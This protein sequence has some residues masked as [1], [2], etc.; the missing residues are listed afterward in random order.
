MIESGGE[1]STDK[2][3]YFGGRSERGLLN[4]RKEGTDRRESRIGRAGKVNIFCCLL[5]L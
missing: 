2:M 5:K 3:D 4:M 1:V